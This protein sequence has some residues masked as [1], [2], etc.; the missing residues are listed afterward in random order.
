MMPTDGDAQAC[1][2]RRGKY[3]LVKEPAEA[4]GRVVPMPPPIPGTPRPVRR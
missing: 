3:N 2:R 4:A 1:Q